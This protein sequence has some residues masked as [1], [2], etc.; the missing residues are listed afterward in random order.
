MPRP[1]ALDPLILTVALQGLEAQRAGITDQIATVQQM[2]GNRPAPP[3]GAIPAGV[4]P[5]RV[6]S[7]AARWRMAAAQR[8][9]WAAVKTAEQASKAPAAPKQ[10]AL[11]KRKLSAAARKRIAAAQKAR[12]AAYH[13]AQAAAPEQPQAKGAKAKKRRLSAAGRKA[14]ADAARRRWAAVRQKAAQAEKAA[15]RKAVKKSRHGKRQ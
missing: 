9:R 2:L 13:K 3:A 14:M 7:P 11:P 4:R 12:W 8:R 5:K 1:P 10:A 15:A 6:V